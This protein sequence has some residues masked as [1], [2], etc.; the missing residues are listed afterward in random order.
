M[1]FNTL[2]ELYRHSIH[3]YSSNTCS[4]LYGGESLTYREFSERVESLIKTFTEAG[5]ESGDKVALL[6]SNM[7]NWG[8]T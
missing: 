7:P 6:S 8:V 4:S 1:P 3:A 5:L 2:L